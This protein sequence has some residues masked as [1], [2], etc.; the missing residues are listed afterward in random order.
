MILKVRAGTVAEDTAANDEDRDTVNEVVGNA[1]D[2]IGDTVA[3][4]SAN[5]LLYQG[6]LA[7]YTTMIAKVCRMEQQ[8]V[9]PLLLRTATLCMCK[10]MCV[11]QRYCQE[12]IDALLHL[13]GVTTDNESQCNI[14]LALGDLIVAN[15]AVM[16]QRVSCLYQCLVPPAPVIVRRNALMVLIHLIL[17]GMVK[18]KGQIGEMARCI[19][20]A[21]PQMS[22]LARMFF[23]ELAAKDNAVYNNLT[24][25]ISVLS[26]SSGCGDASE[27]GEDAVQRQMK[28]KNIMRFLFTFIDKER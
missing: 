24:D 20:S 23:T 5:E 16:D 10:L 2:E 11:S 1:D 14:V 7:P 26:A 22:D 27:G 12:N 15:N 17:N 19:D 3:D 28:F 13:L 9:N 6:A 25:I 8:Y 18:I 4:I 21:D